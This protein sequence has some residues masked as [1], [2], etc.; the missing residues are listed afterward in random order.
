MQ[1]KPFTTRNFSVTAALCLSVIG[2]RVRFTHMLIHECIY[3]GF[4][5][6]VIPRKYSM[7]HG[8]FKSLQIVFCCPMLLTRSHRFYSERYMLRTYCVLRGGIT[9]GFLNYIKHTPPRTFNTVFLNVH[10]IQ[11]F[12]QDVYIR[13]AYG[14][15]IS[16]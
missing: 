5:V 3:T 9:A 7:I 14:N 1:G 11:G 2:K 4:R 16:C 13:P 10:G 12:P 8:A 6:H 15:N